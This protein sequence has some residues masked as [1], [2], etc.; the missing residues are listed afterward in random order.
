MMIIIM[1]MTTSFSVGKTSLMHQF[2]NNVF[3]IHYKATIGVDILSKRVFVDGQAMTLQ[4]R[5]F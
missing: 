1:L 2:V 3:S 5:S 4:V